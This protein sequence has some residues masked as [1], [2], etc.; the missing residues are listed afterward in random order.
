MIVLFNPRSSS[1]GKAILPMSVLALAAALENKHEY[2]IVDG[3]LLEDPL[4][5]IREHVAAGA[6]VLAITVMPGRQVR[7]AIDVSRSIKSEFPAVRVVWGGYFPTMHADV[8]MSE[9]YVDFLFRGHA[10]I[11]FVALV[12]ALESGNGWRNQA[13]LSWRDPDSGD[14]HHNPQGPVPDLDT[15]ADFPY[16]RM[17][18]ESYMLDTWL[19]SRTIPH[20]ASYGCPFTCS[21]CGVVN[22]VGG[23]Y[24]AQSPE[25]LESA[26][27]RLVHE[28]G[29][30]A[31]QFFD[32]NFFVNE[33]RTREICERLAPMRIAWWAYARI[34]TLMKYRDSTWEL[35]RDSGLRM[36]YLGAEAGSDDALERMNK[37][38]RQT[39]DLAIRIAER[40]RSFDIIPEMSFV[41]GCPPD[42]VAD[43]E[44]TFRFIRRIKAVNP[45][46]E[47]VLYLY[48]PV[49]VA[50]DLYDE[51]RSSGFEFPKTLEEWAGDRWVAL[52]ERTSSDLPWLT[53]SV[54]R[55]IGNFQKVLHAAYP[56]ET[57]PSLRGLRR[58][59]LRAAG[60]WRYKLRLYSAPLDLKLVNRLVPHQRPEITGF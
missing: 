41:I 27:A 52:A 17:D 57:D 19:G 45:V 42:P 24:S 3:N 40:M 10:D 59:L 21:F 46:A 1:S 2:A 51:A 7:Q 18:M 56:T 44:R 47:I 26:V 58:A 6:R 8:A 54:R 16:H 31:V 28:Y 15:L 11:P 34:D 48:T 50:G 12:D 35:M 32:N 13:G 43:I 33:S 25:R 55:R 39:T 60:L 49:P 5:A 14:I 9:P 30:N 53:P 36:A 29:A 20:H 38:G 22:M 4:H 23:R 37:G